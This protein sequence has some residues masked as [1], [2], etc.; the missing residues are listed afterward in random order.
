MISGHKVRGREM[1][2][3]K[4]EEAIE[5]LRKWFGEAVTIWE[6]Y[7]GDEFSHKE[8]ELYDNVIIKKFQKVNDDQGRS[9][10]LFRA[11]TIT[12]D[13]W[14]GF[15]PSEYLASS[16][17]AFSIFGSI[18]VPVDMPRDEINELYKEATKDNGEVNFWMGIDRAG[19]L[20]WEDSKY[21]LDRA[22][23]DWSLPRKMQLASLSR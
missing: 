8:R 12:T 13:I 14:L 17:R 2:K 7:T 4:V 9:S 1:D 16:G 10:I 3:Q 20:K 21:W 15:L 18:N 23:E 22:L 11:S 5:L 6:T 19:D